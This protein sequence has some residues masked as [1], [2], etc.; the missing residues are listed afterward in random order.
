MYDLH[1]PQG[2]PIRPF[3]DDF[4]QRW[5]DAALAAEAIHNPQTDAQGQFDLV[6]GLGATYQ[7]N[8]ADAAEVAGP[9]PDG[10]RVLARLTGPAADATAGH[11]T[12]EQIVWDDSALEYAALPNGTAW[13]SEGD[14]QDDLQCRQL[15]SGIAANTPVEVWPE[16]GDDGLIRW[17]FNAPGTRGFWAELTGASGNGQGGYR[18]PWTEQ[19]RTEDGFATPVPARTG[20]VEDDG[21]YAR[22]AAEEGWLGDSHM[23]PIPAG[24]VVWMEAGTVTIGE[25][26]QVTHTF[27]H[28]PYETGFGVPAEGVDD[29]PV[30]ATINLVVT[31]VNGTPILDADGA[32]QTITVWRN[33]TK[34][35]LYLDFT[36]STIFYYVKHP[37]SSTGISGCL[38]SRTE[39]MRADTVS[40]PDGGIKLEGSEVAPAATDATGDYANEDHLYVTGNFYYERGENTLGNWVPWFAVD[41]ELLGDGKVFTDAEDTTKGFL[42]DEIIVDPGEGAAFWIE[43]T[44]DP[45][46]ENDNKLLLGHRDP[47]AQD[48][49]TTAI[50]SIGAGAGTI[51]E[52]QGA[53]LSFDAKGHNRAA[54]LGTTTLEQQFL[55][56]DWLTPLVGAGTGDAAGGVDVTYQHEDAQASVVSLTPVGSY[57]NPGTGV[58]RLN[59]GTV[60]VDARGHVN[61]ADV[62]ANTNDIDFVATS[63]LTR[64]V[65][66]AGGDATVTYAI[67]FT[68]I[69]GYSAGARQVLVNNAGTIR[70]ETVA[71]IDVVDD[72]T[73]STSTG[74]LAQ[75]KLTTVEVISGGTN[76]DGNNIDTAEDC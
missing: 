70:W 44:V 15:V 34:R 58:V 5:N 61:D 63:P 9:I 75:D 51:V 19:V 47:Q 39:G 66:A 42:D 46:G 21:G 31:G 35:P 8:P 7:H 55:G 68:A 20:T 22:N 62:A 48:Y 74:V 30:S 57:T 64:T 76:S 23:E 49:T 45:G 10:M 16:I 71:E 14:D 29:L 27:S 26:E 36:S 24:T 25:E 54:G 1:S 60:P 6:P 50:N 43:K 73:Y 3:S 65:S 38:F 13:D 40:V 17:V 52:I 12:A 72:V 32:Q 59:S 2:E 4:Q 67:D 33:A 18:Y 69:P 11:Y 41:P 37:N 28:P 53:D 56:D